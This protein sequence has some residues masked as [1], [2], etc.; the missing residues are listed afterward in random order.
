MVYAISKPTI[1]QEYGHG[2]ET[3]G[4]IESSQNGSGKQEEAITCFPS[5]GSRLKTLAQRRYGM[6]ASMIYE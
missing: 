3:Q 6:G 2:K 1:P 5:R 4:R